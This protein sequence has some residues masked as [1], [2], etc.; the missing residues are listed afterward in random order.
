[1]EDSAFD[2]LL[3]NARCLD[4]PESVIDKLTDRIARAECTEEEAC[5]AAKEILGVA[6]AAAAILVDWHTRAHGEGSVLGRRGR[7]AGLK[8]ATHHNGQAGVIKAYDATASRFEVHLDN[9]KQLR[10]N[11]SNV[12]L[13][14]VL[15]TLQPEEHAPDVD[16]VGPT[17]RVYLDGCAA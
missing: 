11:A 13:L 9:S 8:N 16:D 14:D 10:V 3:T 12:L 7:I 6:C 1:M 5:A 17:N 2:K 15:P 4:V